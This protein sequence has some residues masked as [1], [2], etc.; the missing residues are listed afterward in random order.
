ML[1]KRIYTALV[2]IPLVLATVVFSPTLWFA[3]IFG[4]VIALATLEWA[5][6]CGLSQSY[7]YLYSLFVISIMAGL[8]FL[9]DQNLN[10][11]I[12]GSSLI[13]WLFATLMI[14]AYQ[15]GKQLLPKS[16]PV[17][18][19]VG[20]AL[21]IPSW[22]SLV[23]LK[24]VSD[25]FQWVLAL[26]FLIWSADTGA[27]LIGRR[28]GKHKMIHRVSPGKSWEG[29]AAGIFSGLLVGVIYV[30]VSGSYINNPALFYCVAVMTVTF[31]IIGDLME[32]MVKRNA[33]V[34]D[35]GQLLPGHGG[36]L[37]RIDSLTAGGPVFLSAL[38]FFGVIS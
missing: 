9:D 38:L 27:Y 37:D 10:L 8:F 15:F 13:F 5:R 7:T 11:W 6:I 34:K 35:S 18:L 32:S 25:E 20:F 21:F 23:Y 36:I 22:L 24:D 16:K 19:M 2:L 12:V 4:L 30:I 33:G 31:S 3:V 1:K 28:W 14:I 26:L 17:M 29:S